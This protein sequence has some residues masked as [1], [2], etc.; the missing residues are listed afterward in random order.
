MGNDQS[1]NRV[2]NKE[3]WNQK[4]VV[5]HYEINLEH[6]P[7]KIRSN[8]EESERPNNEEVRKFWKK[9]KNPI[10]SMESCFKEGEDDVFEE[11]YCIIAPVKF[12]YRGRKIIRAELAYHWFRGKVSNSYKVVSKCSSEGCIRPE[13]LSLYLK[14]RSLKNENTEKCGEE[15]KEGEEEEDPIGHWVCDATERRSKAAVAKAKLKEKTEQL[16]EELRRDSKKRKIYL[17]L[18]KHDPNMINFIN[19][20]KPTSSKRQRL[21]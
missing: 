11:K 19:E 16:A 9:Q 18:F 8:L 20:C 6:P 12:Q 13:H 4:A 17:N 5:S 15:E 21:E 1:G 3:P 10:F 14:K 2:W 7:Y